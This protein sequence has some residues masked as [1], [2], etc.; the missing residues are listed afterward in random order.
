MTSGGQGRAGAGG[1]QRC[2][3]RPP[4]GRVLASPP[5]ELQLTGQGTESPGAPRLSFPANPQTPSAPARVQGLF[6]G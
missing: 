4:V 6:S 5:L 3:K 1:G 2:G